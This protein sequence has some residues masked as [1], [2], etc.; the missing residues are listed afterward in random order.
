MSKYVGR[1]LEVKIEDFD[2]EKRKI[3]LSR[4]AIEVYLNKTKIDFP[5]EEEVFKLL[6]NPMMLT[7]YCSS[8][9]NINKYSSSS[10]FDFKPTFTS[11]GELMWN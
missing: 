6:S 3:V 1:T 4:K 8:N 9:K 5:K 10:E 2:A 7:L 11:Q